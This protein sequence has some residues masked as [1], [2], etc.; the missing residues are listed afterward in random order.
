MNLSGFKEGVLKLFEAKTGNAMGL[1]IGTGTLKMAEVSSRG[2][3][4]TVRRLA[5][6]DMPRGIIEDGLIIDENA[7]ADYIGRLMTKAGASTK[8]VVTAIGGRTIFVREVIFPRM[9]QAELR[10]AIKWDLEKYVPFS[11]ENL[12]FDFSIIGAGAT[13]KDLR[14]LLV[15]APMDMVNTVLR[16]LQKAGLKAVALDIEP[17]A[18]YRTMASAE[19]SLLVDMGAM[20]SQITLFQQGG[21]VFMRSIPFGGQRFTDVIMEVLEMRWTE[22]ERLK[23]RQAG[24][25]APV[26]G[27]FGKLPVSERLDRVVNEIAGEVRRTVEYYQ[28]QNKN[29]KVDRV[30]LSGGGAKLDQ[31]PAR[32]SRI[33]EMP[34]FLQDPF[35]SVELPSSFDQQSVRQLSSQM[36]VAIGLA[37]RGGSE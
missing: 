19:N 32:L 22:A 30:F 31:L 26:E 23:Q 25:L 7:L 4:S 18:A 27:A 20:I 15:A 1:D 37:L 9:D 16:V 14:V 3:R 28:V 6:I 12:Y 11:P 10:E 13:E 21:P 34:V 2:G 35:A 36:S 24:L 33:L 29:A 5:I 8:Q 17:L